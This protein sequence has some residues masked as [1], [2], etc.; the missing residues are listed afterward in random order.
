MGILQIS[1]LQHV[2]KEE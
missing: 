1:T 2:S